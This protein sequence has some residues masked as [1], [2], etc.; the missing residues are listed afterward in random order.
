[1]P[2]DEEFALSIYQALRAQ[3]SGAVAEIS[4]A[5]GLDADQSER[6]WRRLR[7]PSPIWSGIGVC[8]CRWRAGACV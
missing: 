8:A 6:G 3:G 4:A 7:W 1:M 2:G 5:A